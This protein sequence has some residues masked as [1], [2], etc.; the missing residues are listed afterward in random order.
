MGY[1]LAM[2]DAQRAAAYVVAVDAPGWPRV[3]CAVEPGSVAPWVARV[4][5]SDELL[6]LMVLWCGGDALSA[7]GLRDLAA[8]ELAL[9]AGSYDRG[10]FCYSECVLH[11]T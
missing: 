1:Q 7:A 4:C 8:L 6:E 11:E 5:S 10:W 9:E 2:P 3:R